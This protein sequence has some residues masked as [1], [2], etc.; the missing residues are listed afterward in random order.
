[1]PID[2]S[3]SGAP[4]VPGHPFGYP[5]E[6][7]Y[8]GEDL[9]YCAGNAPRGQIEGTVGPECDMT[10]GSSGGQPGEGGVRPGLGEDAEAP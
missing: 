3:P 10:G 7:K 6:K 2:L 1:M 4:I 5:A 8:K 9:I